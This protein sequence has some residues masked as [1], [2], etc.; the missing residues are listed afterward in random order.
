MRTEATPSGEDG[1]QALMLA[2][3]KVHFALVKSNACRQGQ[4]T[5]WGQLDLDLPPTWGAGPLYLACISRRI[6]PAK[7]RAMIPD[8]A[9]WQAR[10]PSRRIRQRALAG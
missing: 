7:H 10:P 8:G 6:D 2:M 4:L 9:G 3:K 5:L 1:I